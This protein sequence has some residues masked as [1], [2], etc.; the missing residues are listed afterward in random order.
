MVDKLAGHNLT[1]LIK[2]FCY[3]TVLLGYIFNDCHALRGLPLVTTLNRTRV[4]VPFQ[5]LDRSVIE[6]I[7]SSPC[8]FIEPFVI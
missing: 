1:A 7:K 3:L 6:V 2:Y 4:D 5:E 8:Q